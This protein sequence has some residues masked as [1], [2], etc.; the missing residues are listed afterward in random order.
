[1]TA[2]QKWAKDKP[3]ITQWIAPKLAML[4]DDFHEEIRQAKF[5]RLSNIKFPQPDLAT[6]H[7]MYRSSRKT[8]QFVKLI[9]E[10]FVGELAECGAQVIQESKKLRNVDQATLQAL[11]PTSEEWTEI[12]SFLRELTDASFAAYEEELADKPLDPAHQEAIKRLLDEYPL[13]TS[14]LVFVT[15]PCWLLYRMPPAF[16]YRKARQHPQH[17]TKASLD[18]LDKLLR[19]DP[20]MLHDISIGKQIAWYRFNST[21]SKYKKLISA[22][23][24]QPSGAKS[25]K[26]ILLSLTGFL[27]AI[28]QHTQKPLTSLDIIELIEA[29]D[30]DAKRNFAKDFP[31]DQGAVTR[32]LQPDRNLWRK[33]ITTDKKI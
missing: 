9:W 23:I 11:M 17:D 26:N 8:F 13:E 15:V 33:I 31:K 18:A 25:R 22:T 30:Q 32:A 19:L 2:V 27:S 24:T 12:L 1:M 4:V 16:L 7:K 29:M 28:S 5:H 14:F 3:I 20:L 21:P 10:V 6:W